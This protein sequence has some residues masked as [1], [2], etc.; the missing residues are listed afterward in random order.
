M[1][2]LGSNEIDIDVIHLLVLFEHQ[3]CA[4]C[5]DTNAICIFVLFRHKSCAHDFRV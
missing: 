2:F 4:H 5:L 1:F 3:C